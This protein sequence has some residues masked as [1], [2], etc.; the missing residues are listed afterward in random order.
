[1]GAG[2]QQ[3]AQTPSAESLLPT[4]LE[5][6]GV[7]ATS[8]PLGQEQEP[9]DTNTTEQLRRQSIREGKRRAEN[10]DEQPNDRAQ[11][12]QQNWKNQQRKREQQE[13]QERERVLALIRHDNEERKAKEMRKK[14][15]RLPRDTI[16]HVPDTP[17]PEK[18]SQFRIQVRLFD[19][20]SIRSSFSPTQT[21][22]R[23]VRPWIDR[24]RT[25][26]DTPYTLK[27]ILTPL[28]NKNI[29][30][31]EEDQKLSELDLGPTASFVMVPVRTYTEAYT[32]T[33]SLPVRALF[34]GYSLITGTIGAVAGGIGS[35]LGFGSGQPSQTPQ[36][37]SYNATPDTA[38]TGT[39]PRRN[40]T[41]MPRTARSN[42]RTL[43]DN[44]NEQPQQFYN[45][46]Q[47]GFLLDR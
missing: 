37:A 38:S 30:V 12:S 16:A 34:G 19:G 22:R 1:M 33:S 4:Q 17:P 46:N 3:G 28:P 26:G 32:S 35:L 42:V 2:A 31:A 10:V 15:P 23:D 9:R 20:T 7:P 45:G 13:K 27:H 21:I 43:H 41:P 5:T 14:M 11:T 8:S 25:D 40:N 36:S 44:R 6:V 18:R 24:E 29:S 47:V 39:T